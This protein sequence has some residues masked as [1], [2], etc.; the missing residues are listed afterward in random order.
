MSATKKEGSTNPEKPKGKTP[1]TPNTDELRRLSRLHLT[2]QEMADWLDCHITTLQLPQYKK[3]IH[4]GRSE[5]KQR[6]KQKVIQRALDDNSDTALIFALKNY[7]GWS[8]NDKVEMK[9]EGT[10]PP[11]SLVELYQQLNPSKEEQS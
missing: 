4:D 5:T 11:P 3:I 2:D 9:I 6:L 10:V 1:V 7:C 8:N